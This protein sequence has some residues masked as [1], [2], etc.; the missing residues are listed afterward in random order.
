MHVAGLAMG[1]ALDQVDQVDKSRF[2]LQDISA[3]R[4]LLNIL[5]EF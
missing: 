5:N 4:G 2:S 3:L 1:R